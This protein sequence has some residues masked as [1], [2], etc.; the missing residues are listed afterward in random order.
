MDP[1]QLLTAVILHFTDQST[2]EVNRTRVR[3][4]LRHHVG[5]PDLRDYANA[6]SLFKHYT[7]VLLPAG[8][9]A[10]IEQL[11]DPEPTP[12]EDEEEEAADGAQLP[13]G[14]G[15]GRARTRRRAKE[16]RLIQ[17]NETTTAASLSIPVRGGWETIPNVTLRPLPEWTDGELARRISDL[18]RAKWGEAPLL[19]PGA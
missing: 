15:G 4:N 8:A 10:A 7:N 2:G 18:F 3:A 12:G 6:K 17:I 13:G 19:I 16:L 14:G 5:P 9:I 11:R 1:A